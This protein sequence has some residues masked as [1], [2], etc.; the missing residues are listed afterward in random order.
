MRQS[1]RDSEDDYAKRLDDMKARLEKRPL[2]LEQDERKKAVRELQ[3]KIEY[4]M[5]VAQV[6]DDDLKRQ[7]IH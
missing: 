3:K 4:A 2:L 7:N 5:K 6:T 1:I